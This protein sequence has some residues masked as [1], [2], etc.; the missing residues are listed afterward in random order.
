MYA[1]RERSQLETSITT[2]QNPKTAV[3]RTASFISLT[4]ND[5]PSSSNEPVIST[6]SGTIVSETPI[7]KTSSQRRLQRTHHRHHQPLKPLNGLEIDPI[8]NTSS[9]ML[10]LPNLMELATRTSPLVNFPSSINTL[11]ISTIDS[12]HK[13][14]YETQKD[15]NGINH[16]RLHTINPNLL[17]PLSKIDTPTLRT[18]LAISGKMP[19]MNNNNN[20]NN[21]NLHRSYSQKTNNS[22]AQQ[23]LASIESILKERSTILANENMHQTDTKE[24]VNHILKQLYLPSE[25]TK[26]S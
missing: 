24:R 17:H 22:L 21:G 13:Y 12:S 8:H 6:I 9:P 2:D 14:S 23:P 4:L 25:K 20:N 1:I 10:P 3:K 11:D 7:F 18:N 26:R 16:H 19:S 5:L 15:S